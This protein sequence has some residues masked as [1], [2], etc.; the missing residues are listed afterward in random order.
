MRCNLSTS[1]QTGLTFKQVIDT[2]KSFIH[3]SSLEHPPRLEEGRPRSGLLSQ[4][5]DAVPAAPV[6][7]DGVAPGAVLGASGTEINISTH[8]NKHEFIFLLMEALDVTV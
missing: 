3:V 2:G 8:N 1:T 6:S 5:S 4:K 7:P